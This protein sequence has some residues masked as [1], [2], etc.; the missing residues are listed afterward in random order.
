MKVLLRSIY[1]VYNVIQR[2]FNKLVVSSF[3][4]ARFGKCGKKITIGA[5]S[6]FYGA[7]NLILGDDISIGPEAMFM[8]TRAKIHIG[9]HVMFGPKV[10][11]IT[12]GHRIDMIGK[13]M[14]QIEGDEKL[15]ENDKDI[16]IEG[17]NWIGANATIL[18]GVTIGVGAVVAAN[19]VVTRS[20]PAYAVVGGVPAKVLKMRFTDEEIVVHE[21]LLKK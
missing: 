4:K 15:P 19:V 12:G 18:K 10:S 7:D 9:S 13:Y 16:V 1:C 11:M 2:A 20:V 21:Q 3:H 6:K 5:K 17:D 8:C 14:D